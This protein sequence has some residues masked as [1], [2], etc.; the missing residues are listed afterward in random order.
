VEWSVLFYIEI[1]EN[2]QKNI[3]LSFEIEPPVVQGRETFEVANGSARPGQTRALSTIAL[4]V[5]SHFL[6]DTRTDSM[7]KLADAGLAAAGIV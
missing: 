7:N 5:Y 6:R 2:L 4:R 1:R 3:L